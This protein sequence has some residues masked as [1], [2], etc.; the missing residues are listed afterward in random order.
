M[1]RNF[2]ETKSTYGRT[3]HWKQK[4]IIG[5]FGYEHANNIIQL[6]FIRPVKKFDS[7]ENCSGRLWAIG[8]RSQ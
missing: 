2:D 6:L 8:N 3:K 1:L 5:Y 4:N 7:A